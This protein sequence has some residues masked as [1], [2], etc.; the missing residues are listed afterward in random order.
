MRTIQIEPTIA[1]ELILASETYDFI[2]W[3]SDWE[4]QYLD[5]AIDSDKVLC[6]KKEINETINSYGY[7]VID[8]RQCNITHNILFPKLSTYICSLVGTPI[9]VFTNKPHWREINVL[10]DKHP[11]RS[12]GIGESKMHI[13][14]VNA[15]LPPDYICLFCNRID[16]LGGGSTLLFDTYKIDDL[17]SN[18]T[19]QVL[20][21]KIFTDGLFHNLSNIGHDISPFSIYNP[22]C[23]WIYRITENLLN[24]LYDKKTFEALNELFYYLKSREKKLLLEKNQ[25]IIIDQHRMLHGKTALGVGQD[26]IPFSS[27]RQLMQSFIRKSQYGR[28]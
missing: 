25:M 2:S 6:L 28:N 4:Y 26:K 15:S 18:S 11:N 27:R 17:L 8:F 9:K 7:L 5:R 13:D 24:N 21:K 3:D 16:S 10:L 14:F 20:K 22:E 12:E 23:E 1:N 19:I